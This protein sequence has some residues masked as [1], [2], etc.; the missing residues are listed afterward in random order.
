MTKRLMT[1]GVIVKTSNALNKY[2]EN[3]K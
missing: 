2:F 3:T 1:K